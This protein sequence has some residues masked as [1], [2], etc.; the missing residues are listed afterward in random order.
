M[1]TAVGLLKILQPISAQNLSV[2]YENRLYI[3]FKPQRGRHSSFSQWLVKWLCNMSSCSAD[4]KLQHQMWKQPPRRDCSTTS[5][6]CIKS[7]PLI[8]PVSVCGCVIIH[9]QMCRLLLWLH[10][11]DISILNKSDNRGLSL[12]K[13]KRIAKTTTKF[14]L[15]FLHPEANQRNVLINPL[16][17]S[18]DNSG[19]CLFFH[20]T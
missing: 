19:V 14:P 10:F 5:H 11:T 18:I 2:L 9:T 4:F 12:K 8:K 15:L 3:S 7:N 17:N 13:G 20:I 1:L 6:N 16:L